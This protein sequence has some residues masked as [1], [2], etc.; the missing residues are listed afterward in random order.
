MFTRLCP[1]LVLALLVPAVASAELFIC[2]KPQ[3]QL[4]RQFYSFVIDHFTNSDV[5]CVAVPPGGAIEE[6]QR[7]LLSR[8][9]RGVA[10]SR[11]LKIA[12]VVGSDGVER[13]LAVEKTEA[14]KDAVDASIESEFARLRAFSTEIR[15]QEYCTP[16]TLDE[17]STK[18]AAV[19]G[20]VL[21]AVAAND[22]ATAF[23]H[24][25][26]LLEKAMRCSLSWAGTRQ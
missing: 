24:T 10:A 9:I 26:D 2:Y 22:P 7:Q 15:T 19:R 21:A 20:Q 23:L 14:E 4:G 12:K 18:I 13:D 5:S 1:A 3:G 25:L 17:L 8:K 11:Y 16:R 6:Q